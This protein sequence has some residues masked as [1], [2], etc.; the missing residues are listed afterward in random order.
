MV[1]RMIAAPQW[2]KQG[3]TEWLCCRACGGWWPV[4]PLL[5]ARSD[6]APVCPHCGGEAASADSQDRNENERG[7]AR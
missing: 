1:A 2:E 6:V 3:S 4:D 7:R 5:L